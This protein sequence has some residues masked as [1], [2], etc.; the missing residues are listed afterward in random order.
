MREI[1]FL[2][3]GNTLL[4]HYVANDY[5]CTVKTVYSTLII[6]FKFRFRFIAVTLYLSVL[7][8]YLHRALNI[9][10]LY[11]LIL[12]LAIITNSKTVPQSFTCLLIFSVTRV[13]L[14]QSLELTA[15]Q[16]VCYLIINSIAS[17]FIVNDVYGMK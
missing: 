12:H 5:F 17:L 9:L 15:F 4:T 6:C 14:K 1:C 11:V 2:K 16:F 3:F 13:H 8:E 7:L 10:E